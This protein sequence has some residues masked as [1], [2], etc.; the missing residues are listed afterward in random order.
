MS[1]AFARATSPI[2]TIFPASPTIRGSYRF[3]NNSNGSGRFTN[4]VAGVTYHA[5]YALDG[6]VD[7][8]RLVF[9]NDTAAAM[10]IN[11][12]SVAPSARLGAGFAPV[13]AEDAPASWTSLGFNNAGADLPF[14]DQLTGSAPSLSVPATADANNPSLACTD[15]GQV[16]TIDRID[17]PGGLPLLFVRSFAA[18]TARAPAATAGD[19]SNAA[20][21]ASVNQGRTIVQGAKTG[22]FTSTNQAGFVAPITA[23][24]ILPVF[25]LQ[26]YRRAPGFSVMT[27]GDSLALGFKTIANANSFGFQACA[28]LSTPARPVTH[29]NAA[30]SGFTSAQYMARAYR[31]IEL[32]RPNVVLVPAMTPNDAAN[33]TVSDVN[34]ALSRMLALCSFCQSRGIVAVLVT[35]VPFINYTAAEDVLRQAINLQVRKIA[36]AGTQPVIDAD[37]AVTDGASPARPRPGLTVGPNADGTHLTDPGHAVIAA[38][39]IP[40]L[41]R[42]LGY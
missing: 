30:A 5:A 38:V 15:W 6:H 12:A 11:A 31:E 36:A 40:V 4:M 26:F 33:L 27:I 7:L 19:F 42:V 34:L 22:D 32:F 2:V 17:E 20:G 21:W 14:Q 8:V 28:A 37:A 29:L 10:V 24:D 16:S 25:G 9:A 13:N 35:A 39:A 1:F 18:T 3:R 23:N 41:R